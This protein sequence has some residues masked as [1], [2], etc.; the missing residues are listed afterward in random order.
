MYALTAKYKYPQIKKLIVIA[1]ESKDSE[2]R[3]EDVVFCRFDNPLS[4]GERLF[5]QSVMHEY[6]ILTD[7]IPKPNNKLNLSPIV[8]S[9]KKP[10]R[11]EPCFCGSGIKYKKCHG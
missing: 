4:K 5:V 7:F 2:G 3:S 8:K 10:G 1:T 11:N 6:S 9:D